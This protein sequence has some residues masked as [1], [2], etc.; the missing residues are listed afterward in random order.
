MW[1]NR[2]V[3]NH[4]KE[5]HMDVSEGNP[6]VD[7]AIV[8]GLYGNQ[9]RLR[10]WLA[11]VI[12]IFVL[13]YSSS[14]M[15]LLWLPPYKGADMRS[16]LIADYSAWAFLLLQPVD[17]AVIEEI[18]QERGLPEQIIIDGFFWPTPT[19]TLS[20]PPTPSST[21]TSAPQATF[22]V[23]SS[24]PT[25]NT[26]TPMPTSIISLPEP[27][28]TPQPTRT[29]IPTPVG[30]SFATATNMFIYYSASPTS[31]SMP[32]ATSTST[33]M[34]ATATPTL[35]STDTAIST[36]TPTYTTTPT[37]T[38]TSTLTP[39]DTPTATP[40]YT[41]T[42]TATLTSIST[43]TSTATP[44]PTFTTIPDPSEPDFGGPDGNTT[45]LGNGMSVEFRL[46]GSLLDGNST[47]DTIYYEKEEAS[48]SSKI[49]LGAVRIEVYDETTAVWYTIYYWGDGIADINASYN[50]ANSEPDGFPV[51]KSDLYGAAPLN[52]GIAID[53]DTRAVEQGAV[54]G[55]S[56]TKIRITSLSNVKCEVDALQMLR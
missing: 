12:F 18:K 11:S 47:W 38:L 53:I 27:T 37:A 6:A 8:S 26:S 28:A 34:A 42:P 45:I 22:D 21:P 17:P 36:T 50:N 1:I 54:I 29:S 56:I 41:I 2:I 39:T 24:S 31:T 25:A 46:S 23:L 9:F 7:T 15:A 20:V 14:Y 48:S 40:T 49:H 5:E 10:S 19:S 55:D 51:D 43:P 3:R 32:G 4:G 13:L 16:Q 30:T 33:V 35:T 52:T 44:T